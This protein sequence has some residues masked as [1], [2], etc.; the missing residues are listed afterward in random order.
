VVIVVFGIAFASPVEAGHRTRSTLASLSH[1]SITRSRSPIPLP[2][3]C[4]YSPQAAIAKAFL[5]EIEISRRQ[6][7][8]LATAPTV[9]YTYRLAGR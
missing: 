6:S 5:H 2:P 8:D 9:S 4:F 7:R 1:H 3:L